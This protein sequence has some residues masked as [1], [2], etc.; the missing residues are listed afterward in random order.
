MLANFFDLCLCLSDNV[1]RNCSQFILKSMWE[2]NV[3]STRAYKKKTEVKKSCS[4]KTKMCKKPVGNFF[5]CNH[6][7]IR[8]LP[9]IIITIAN[10]VCITR[11]KA[12]CVRKR[13]AFQTQQKFVTCCIN[14]FCSDP[15]NSEK[16][17]SLHAWFF[18]DHS[19]GG[20]KIKELPSKNT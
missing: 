16:V 20:P 3:E 8:V 6:K 7:Y 1:L 2:Q 12:I 18:A 10:K 17:F 15:N 19:S 13:V 11:T 14:N 4:Q 9:V 5:F